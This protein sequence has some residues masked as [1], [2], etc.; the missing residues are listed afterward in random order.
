MKGG[1]DYNWCTTGGIN[2]P[3]LHEGLTIIGVPAG[4]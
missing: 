3:L 2:R 4:G 1:I